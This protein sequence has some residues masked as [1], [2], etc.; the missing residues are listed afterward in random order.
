MD[1]KELSKRYGFNMFP[2][3]ARSKIPALEGWI[4]YQTE[5]FT[6]TFQEGQ[7]AAIVCG[8]TSG[9][10]I[11]VDIDSV[12]LLPLFDK[13]RGRT[14]QVKTGE[15]G[16]HFY[17]R[18]PANMPTRGRKLKNAAGNE[19]DIKVQGGYVVAPGS[20]HPKTGLK[21]EIT[22]EAEPLSIDFKEIIKIL[23]DGGMKVVQTRK[24]RRTP[25]TEGDRN[26][27]M[28][29]F[30][31]G[32][33][34]ELGLQGIDLQRI[35]L[36]HNKKYEPPLSE[37]EVITCAEHAEKY[38]DDDEIRPS[39]VEEAIM[40]T[41]D[42]ARKLETI[43]IMAF[44]EDI[45][46]LGITN[47]LNNIREIRGDVQIDIGH[48]TRFRD[49]RPAMFAKEPVGFDAMVIAEDDTG[50][51]TKS[52]IFSCGKCQEKLGEFKC[53]R[54]YRLPTPRCEHCGGKGI[55]DS[56]TG[57]GYFKKLRIQEIIDGNIL[58]NSEQREVEV[59]DDDA[60]KVSVGDRKSMVARFRTIPGK[61]N[62]N[63]ILMEILWMNDMGQEP[64]KMPTIDEVNRWRSGGDI[65]Q[66]A[67]ES[68]VPEV[69]DMDMIKKLM[70]CSMV[71]GISIEGNRS[72]IH[73]AIFGHTG[74]GKSKLLRG[75]TRVVPGSAYVDAGM[76]SAVGL[77]SPMVEISGRMIPG[78]GTLSKHTGSVVGIDEA[79][80]GY[81]E[82]DKLRSCLEDGIVTI[83]KAGFPDTELPADTTIIFTGNLAGKA[84]D[85]SMSMEDN[86]KFEWQ[87]LSRVD[88]V[89]YVQRPKGRFMA[90]EVKKKFSS[91]WTAPMDL[92]ELQRYITFGKRMNLTAPDAI[93]PTVEEVYN[94]WSEISDQY[95]LQVDTRHQYAVYRLA[96]AL[97][98]LHLRETITV[99]DVL[100]AKEM[101]EYAAGSLGIKVEK[102]AD[103]EI[104]KAAFIKKQ[105]VDGTC[106][107]SDI[108]DDLTSR[109]QDQTKAYEIIQKLRADGMISEDNNNCFK[110]EGDWK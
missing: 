10:L 36:E 109:F 84:Y 104:F 20:T 58:S 107:K 27:S 50:T 16:E 49:I 72:N 64:G 11:V 67:I 44:R 65:L 86:T 110:L 90:G 73:I 62:R 19:I 85:T 48:R 8:I 96:G 13:Y 77:L 37:S 66:K 26:S 100:E 34:K 80:M 102:R 101:I 87:I 17:F 61:N 51:Y 21:Y 38:T 28:Y 75:M 92:E 7:N 25:A 22:C 63:Q 43:D 52:G 106:R 69:L 3:R 46:I 91:G 15:R 14:F 93:D 103:K 6:G 82:M 32:C 99:E 12:D 60:G 76:A 45:R 42:I 24:S 39:D 74:T 79:N 31:V 57:E 23:E 41:R 108:V 83:N 97:S 5:Q 30:C 94:F 29:W 40:H 53:D 4:Q 81:L 54:M 70:L 55:M 47:V 56:A 105:R 2:L 33:V 95:G 78:A 88:I 35:A 71:G 59:Y 68:F 89:V 98:R 18:I 9:N 1:F